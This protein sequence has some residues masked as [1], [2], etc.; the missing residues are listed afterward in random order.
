M[1]T[2]IGTTGDDILYGTAR[3]DV[4]KGRWHGDDYLNGGEGDDDLFGTD[5][6][7]VF[8]TGT[9]DDQVWMGHF[10]GV[11]SDGAADVVFITA[12]GDP[13]FANNN[14]AHLPNTVGDEYTSIYGFGS[15]DTVQFYNADSALTFNDGATIEITNFSASVS[16]VSFDWSHFGDDTGGNTLSINLTSGAEFTH[17]SIGGIEYHGDLFGDNSY[18]TDYTFVGGYEQDYYTAEDSNSWDCLL[19]TSP[20]PRDGLLSRMPSSA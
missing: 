11:F 14:A 13:D 6:A 15:E 8:D 16:N 2:I 1:T 12:F 5:G 7:N 17:T 3:D 19:Y 9:G 10:N 4:I 18:G 20:S